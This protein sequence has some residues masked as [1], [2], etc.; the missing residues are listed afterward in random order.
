[1]IN[2]IVCCNLGAKFWYHGTFFILMFINLQAYD[3]VLHLEVDKIILPGT[4][5]G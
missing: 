4:D 2:S 1:M 3:H 5:S